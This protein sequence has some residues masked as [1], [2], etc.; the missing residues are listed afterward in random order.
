MVFVFVKCLLS[1]G[2]VFY[3]LHLEVFP[4]TS[5][6]TP[7]L[8]SRV[9]HCWLCLGTGRSCLGVP[10]AS[11][12]QCPG[13]KYGG[14]AGAGALLPSCSK[15]N[16]QPIR[17]CPGPPICW[18]LL[19]PLEPLLWLNTGTSTTL[20]GFKTQPWHLGPWESYVTLG[21]ISE[22]GIVTVFILKD[23]SEG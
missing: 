13:H 11:L 10:C 5:L 22:V 2:F 17:A 20:L 7:I 23:F 4:I 9:S 18:L 19:G 8:C 1:L 3:S 16:H 14:R 15:P 6:W 12:P 21:L